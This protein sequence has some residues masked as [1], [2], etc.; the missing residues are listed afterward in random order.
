MNNNVSSL[1]SA[2]TSNLYAS[3]SNIVNRKNIINVGIITKVI[4]EN[5]VNVKLYYTDTESVPVIISSVRLL[6]I[7]TAKCK[8]NIQPAVGDN[9][10]LFASKDFIEKLEYQHEP[11]EKEIAIEPYDNT[12]IQGILISPEGRDD[13]KV[14][15]KIDEEGSIT[16]ETEKDISVN[17]KG[18]ASVVAD[19]DVTVEAKNNATVKSQNTKLT[20]GIVEIG[21]AVTPSGQGALCGIPYCVY[22][23]APQTGKQ[24]QGA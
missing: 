22:S 12:T 7:G 21:G 1:L 16:L 6:H 24:T 15:I 19:G 17:A 18:N 5:F 13:A 3:L 20:G 10:L 8:I 23:G 4:D 14:T 9:V 2:E 11:K